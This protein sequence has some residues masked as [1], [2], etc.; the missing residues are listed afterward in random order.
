MNARGILLAIALVLALG[1]GVQGQTRSVSELLQEGMYAEKTEG[2]LDKAIGLYEQIIERAEASEIME[3]SAT[4]HLGLCYLKKGQKDQAAQHF[5]QAIE[6]YPEQ[7]SMIRKA[8][9]HLKKLTPASHEQQT[10]EAFY[11]GLYGQAPVEVWSAISGLYG[12][13]CSRAGVKALYTNSNIHFVNPD[14]VSWHGGYGYYQ[15]STQEP[16]SGRIRISGTTNPHQKHYDI[17]G[18]VLNTEIVPDER[19]GRKNY[20]HVYL[21]LPQTLTPGQYFPYGWA[22]D[23]SV[24]LTPVSLTQDRYLLKMQ[25]RFGS[26]AMEVFYLI[27]PNTLVI[28]SEEEPTETVT[29]GDY[30]IYAWE[31]EVQLSENHMVMVTLSKTRDLSP[32]EI[33]AIV[34]K[35]VIT[36]STCGETDPRLKKSMDSLKGIQE[37]PLVTA[38]SSYLDSET[39]IIRRSAIYIFWRGGFSDISAVQ[40]KLLELCGHKENYTRGMAA[41]TLGE[42]KAGGAYETLVDMTLNDK[43]GY[44][45][46]CGA[47]ALGLLGDDKALPTLEQALQDTDDN[48]K[49]NAQAAITMLTKLNNED[50]NDPKPQQ[51]QEMINDIQPDGTIKFKNPTVIENQ[52]S[53]PITE[54]H[55]MNSDFVQLTAM[56]DEQGNPLQFTTKHDGRKYHY[57]VTFAPPVMPGESFTYFS[58]GTIKGLVKP[59]AHRKN[60]FRY[61]MTHSPGTGVP[62]LRI[63]EYLLPA[64]AEVLSMYSEEMVQSTKEGRI[65]LRIEKV[66]P[67]NGS[68]T[69]SFMYRLAPPINLSTPEATIRSFVNAV[70]NGNLDAAKKCV[71]KDGHDYDEFMEM[72]AI[73]SNHPFQAMIKAKDSD[74]PVE[75][76]NKNIDKDTCKIKWHFTLGRVYYLD[77][78]SKMPKGTQQKFGSYLEL[79]DGKWLIRDI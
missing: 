48:V 73:K 72:L 71:S 59:A 45:R 49:S 35:A 2:N 30:T 78:D 3:A 57:H 70:Y 47:Y 13:T 77:G 15:N 24:K 38:L 61:R 17:M 16:T 5:R 60:T 43:D 26:H 76:I 4:Y 41:L 62:T 74:I 10:S 32:Q 18:N 27:I 46:R 68:L 22:K 28:D 6:E 54:K 53:A 20:Y 21:D 33:V 25:N 63:E 12:Q 19:P 37:I 36:I 64:G 42:H 29:V 58:K 31:K 23:G 9:T 69:T 1:L 75:I 65:S 40:T 56:T 66:I 52:G 51:T 44:A 67:A 39:Q 79:V 55:F 14:F 50:K 8:K 11:G 34:E 7:S